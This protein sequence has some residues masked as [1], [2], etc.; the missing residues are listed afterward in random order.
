MKR[1][2]L[3]L[4]T[5]FA[6]TNVFAAPF[7]TCNPYPSSGPLPDTFSVGLDSGALISV[8][9]RKNAD[10]SRDLYYDLGPLGITNGSHQFKVAA[11]NS[12]WGSSTQVNFTF[13]KAV[14]SAPSG[15]GLTDQ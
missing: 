15:L 14:P 10:G 6:S 8:P 3:L 11:V 2:M 5:I 9:A 12:V 7:L 13:V 4:A 1:A